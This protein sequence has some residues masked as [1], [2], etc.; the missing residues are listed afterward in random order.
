MCLRVFVC[1]R[2]RE[3]KCLCVC[4]CLC[5]RERERERERE[6]RKREREKNADT[7]SVYIMHRFC[8]VI[9]GKLCDFTVRN[10]SHELDYELIEKK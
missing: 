1:V 8:L 4:L 6:G 2:D 5:D 10:I 3:R 9:S 7:G